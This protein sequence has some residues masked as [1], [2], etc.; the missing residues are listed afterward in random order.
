[1]Q[2]TRRL[3]IFGNRKLHYQ[4]PR[5]EVEEAIRA[6]VGAKAGTDI[7]LD[8]IKLGSNPGL[9]TQ[10]MLAA[11]R[12]ASRT[13]PDNLLSNI[14]SAKALVEFL[15]APQ[16][17]P[18]IKGIPKLEL[19]RGDSVP[20]NITLINYRKKKWDA[21]ASRDFIVSSITDAGLRCTSGGKGPQL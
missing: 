18:E 6:C 3:L 8:G 19:F 12:A 11:S 21:N 7:D 20:P 13:I 10:I 17:L 1:M 4:A 16:D 2:L 14:K 15:C 9:D 5:Q